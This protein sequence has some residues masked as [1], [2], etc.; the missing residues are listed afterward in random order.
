MLTSARDDSWFYRNPNGSRY[1]NNGQG[2][3]VYQYPRGPGERAAEGYDYRQQDGGPWQR[4]DRSSTGASVGEQVNA[5]QLTPASARPFDDPRNFDTAA[6]DADDID[7]LIDRMELMQH[8]WHNH[9]DNIEPEDRHAFDDEEDEEDRSACYGPRNDV[10]E[11]AS[12]SLAGDPVVDASGSNDG[13]EDIE[14]AAETDFGFEDSGETSGYNVSEHD[15]GYA[16]DGFDGSY[17]DDGYGDGCNG[18]YE[19]Y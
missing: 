7:E 9:P 4:I 19:Y 10:Q 3:A 11:H 14:G 6:K 12:P 8:S 16:D 1:Y 2:T 18:D 13:Y 15:G 5:T 17:D